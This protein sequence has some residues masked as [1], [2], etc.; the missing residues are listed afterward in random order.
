ML[1]TQIHIVKHAPEDANALMYE[2]QALHGVLQSLKKFQGA[3]G[4]H[5][6]QFGAN[7]MFTSAP[8]GCAMKILDMKNRVDRLNSPGVRGI[9][10]RGKW[11][12]KQDERLEIVATLHRSLSIFQLLLSIDGM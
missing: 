11:Y 10:E 4:I 7:S 8:Q 2:L 12:Y 9:I 3:Q 6:R 1:Y 5:E